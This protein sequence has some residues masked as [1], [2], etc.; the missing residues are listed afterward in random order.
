MAFFCFKIGDGGMIEVTEISKFF[1]SKTVVD[2]LSFSVRKGEIF[3]FLG[4]NGAGKTTAIRMM[5]GLLRPSAG[6]IQIDRLNVFRQTKE[7]HSRIGIVFELP[8]L[9]NRMS[10]Y[11]NLKLFADLYKVPRT[12]IHEIMDSLQLVDKQHMKVE[13]LSKGWKQRVLIGR[14][15]LHHPKVL[16]L[17]EPTSGLDP[18]TA[19][20]IRDYIKQLQREG[21]TIVI[22]THDMHEADEVSDRVGIMHNG[23]LIEVD[24]PSRLKG[25]FGKKEIQLEYLAKGRSV[26]R[27]IPFGDE[28]AAKF[29]Y[30]KLKNGEIISIHSKEASLADVFAKLTGSE[31]S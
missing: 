25:R 11:D 3:G 16:F 8:N 30:D 23:K 12:R 14:A 15:L 26:I 7:V 22:T 5:I 1:G 6:D 28:V 18:N 13:K 17:D 29:L 4:P 21:T 31:L 9:Y 24:T 27:N 20:L 2:N 10:I 19:I